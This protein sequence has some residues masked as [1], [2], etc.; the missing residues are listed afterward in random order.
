MTNQTVIGITGGRIASPD[1]RVV[2]D[3]PPGAV[4]EDLAVSIHRQETSHPRP[5][6]PD[7]RF[8]AR[9]QFE[10]EAVAGA[11]VVHRFDEPL[12]FN[13]R[14]RPGD[15]PPAFDPATLAF[16]TLDEASQ[17]WVALPSAVG[18]EELHLVGQADHFSEDAIT[19]NSLVSMAPL[20]DGENVGMQG[21]S[22]ELPIPIEVPPGRGGLAPQL[23]FTYSSNRLFG[24]RG[25]ADHASWAGLGWEL[26]TP[27][28]QVDWWSANP[29]DPP[30]AFV[31]V[32][33]V[34]GEMMREGTDAGQHVWRLRDENYWKIR[35]TCTDF[36]C[37]VHVWDQSGTKYVFGDTAT[38]DY[39]R[40]YRDASDNRKMYRL[41]LRFIEDALGNKI[42][43]EY[44][45]QKHDAPQPYGHD[46]VMAA[47]PKRISYNGGAAEVLFNGG[48]PANNGWEVAYQNPY[49]S[50]ETI[51]QRWDTPHDGED[52]D[53]D[54]EDDYVAPRI[55]ETRK[56]VSVD[57]KVSGNLVR[58]YLP[59]FRQP[60]SFDIE[61]WQERAAAGSPDMHEA[62]QLDALTMTDRNGTGYIFTTT[63]FAYLG[64]Q[65]QYFSDT[66]AVFEY[67]RPLLDRATNGFGGA[68]DF[69]YAWTG[70]NPGTYH[71]ERPV[72]SA[73]TKIPGANQPNITTTYAR[74][75]GNPQYWKN[76]NPYQPAVSEDFSAEFRGF[77][78]VTETDAEGNQ[79]IHAYKPSATWAD[80][81]LAGR[82][83]DVEVKDAGGTSWNR[84]T[85][86]YKV[87]SVANWTSS[88]G[89]LV[90]F[91]APE[92]TTTTLR[93]GAQFRQTTEYDE[94]ASSCSITACQGLVSKVTDE[95]SLSG[96]GDDVITRTGFHRNTTDWIFV[97]RYSEQLEPA[98]SNAVLSC[99]RLYYDGG[100]SIADTP[101]NGLITA[102]SLTTA[103]A[104]AITSAQC[105]GA[106]AIS[107]STNA[108]LVYDAYGNLVQASV[109]TATPPEV[110]AGSGAS[111]WIPPSLSYALTVYDDP[112]DLAHLF[113]SRI[114]NPEG[115]ETTYEYDYVLGKPTTVTAPNGRSTETR[116]D[117]LGRVTHAWDN[118]DSETYPSAK[119]IYNWGAVP[120]R[121]LTE[122]RTVHGTAQVTRSAVC[123][124]GFG[125][126][127][128]RRAY[129]QAS[130]VNS[131][132]T[133]YDAV[134]RKVVETAP[135]FH[136]L[137]FSCPAGG[138]PTSARNRTA[139]QYDPLGNVVRTTF[140]AANASSGPSTAAS[141][142]GLV[143]AVTDERGNTTTQIS[144]PAARTLT[145]TEPSTSVGVIKLR[146]SSQ[147][148]YEQWDFEN[149][150]AAHYLN[151][152]DINADNEASQYNDQQWNRKDTQRFPAA[153]LAA[154]AVVESVTFKFRWKHFDNVTPN[155]SGPNM[156]ALFRQGGQD[157]RGPTFR[158]T[159]AEGW[160]EGSWTMEVNPGTWTSSSLKA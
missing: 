22:A 127:F 103:A 143:A 155:P 121:T 59:S 89:F 56:L 47:Y 4:S 154:D 36:D 50:D 150:A 123:M 108:Y 2:I 130:L 79:V 142:G 99:S 159:N 94:G 20:L 83:Y 67:M 68:V 42:D 93:G 160:V 63:S 98:P 116:Y 124:D 17:A 112:A 73:E 138:A 31:S 82:E 5:A 7:A 129:Y 27:N 132:R 72:V 78:G 80:Q 115:H 44:W 141:H 24:M 140:L 96:T 49:A 106:S 107:P 146:P 53:C 62:L 157:V 18:S 126:E 19:A 66:A 25:Y 88:T 156:W 41:D 86:T 136:G 120:N 153:G 110:A 32:N 70:E 45:Q 13:F 109:A 137:S 14:F 21:L 77:T 102:T 147:G 38:T 122:T 12:Q 57:V 61:C 128:E 58:R 54:V 100:D 117:A 48:D 75:P 76:V 158:S 51:L 81:P 148:S 85:T 10:A 113:P 119:F 134:G 131:A 90:N 37:E 64:G 91:V 46:E 69:D 104:G 114:I 39:E 43:F 95:G 118:L 135:V 71:W 105:E 97:P 40:W 144:N 26:D 33:G 35:S 1:G 28:I 6:H 34:G 152:D 151:V 29:S 3:F 145:V 60:S 92:T 15:L 11:A 8:V 101:G 65:M 16:W 87:R 111:G 74:V 84:A 149:P 139:Y 9:W 23:A 52:S 30:R 55:R 133:D 125:R